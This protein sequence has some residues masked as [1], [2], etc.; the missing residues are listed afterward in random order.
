MPSLNNISELRHSAVPTCLIS[1][2]R[3]VGRGDSGLEVVRV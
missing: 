1:G 2:P 3:V